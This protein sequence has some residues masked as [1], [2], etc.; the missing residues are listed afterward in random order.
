MLKSSV[1]TLH[2]FFL[3]MQMQAVCGTRPSHLTLLTVYAHTCLEVWFQD[4]GCSVVC[5]TSLHFFDLFLCFIHALQVEVL[6]RAEPD[7]LPVVAPELARSL[8]H[9]KAPIHATPAPT[10]SP[11]APQHSTAQHS[12]QPSGSS[13]EWQASHLPKGLSSS[14]EVQ[15]QRALVAVLALSPLTSGDTLIAELYS[16]NLDQHQRMVILD[17]LAGAAVEMADPRKA[18]TLALQGGQAAP[19]LLPP[20]AAS[21]R[22]RKALAGAAAATRQQQALPGGV[23]SSQANGD[24]S[25]N[26]SSGGKSPGIE[27][28]RAGR[29]QAAPGL[30]EASSRVWGKV[31]LQKQ[32]AAAAS[33]GSTNSTTRTFRNRFAP[34]A[35][36][37]AAALLHQCDVKQQGV[38]LFGRDSLLLGRLLT[39]LGTFVEAAA[40]TPAAVPLCAGLLELLKAKEVSGHKEVCGW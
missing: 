13:S 20:A 3:Q 16:P 2:S 22:G 39:V 4:A 23:R 1:G 9:C 12:A 5:D 11:A 7:E 36:R 38:D 34:V 24:G 28:G 18:P 15:R 17:G 29:S 32:A 14:A 21:A 37:W 19:E 31:S 6:I 26:S 33:N 25:G 40:E 35:V 30:V 8:V 27:K 10:A